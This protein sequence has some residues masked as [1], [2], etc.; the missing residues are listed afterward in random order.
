MGSKAWQMILAA[1]GKC[2][3]QN[4]IRELSQLV[5]GR[6]VRETGQ[7]RV[8]ATE[9]YATA[10]FPAACMKSG[11]GRNTNSGY[12]S[13][14]ISGRSRP[15]TSV[16]METRCPRMMSR[17]QLRTKL[18]VNTKP[19]SVAQPTICATN[20]LAVSIEQPGYGAGNAVP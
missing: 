3:R 15:A 20:W 8:E 5:P 17:I 19:T 9:A 18:K 4:E 2:H 7:G 14:P 10:I 16:S 11:S 13:C 6:A 1:S 12:P